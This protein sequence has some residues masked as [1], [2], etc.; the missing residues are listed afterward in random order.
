SNITMK[1]MEY[2]ITEQ[3]VYQNYSDAFSS[4]S[5]FIAIALDPLHINENT[6]ISE[7]GDIRSSFTQYHQK[8]T[9]LSEQL[10]RYETGL[11]DGLDS[12]IKLEIRITSSL[13]TVLPLDGTLS[14]LR[15]KVLRDGIDVTP[16]FDDSCFH[17]KRLSEEMEGDVQWNTVNTMPTKTISV[18]VTDLVNRSAI[19]ICEFEYFYS[20]TMKI[21]KSGFITLNEE[22]PGPPGEDAYQ[23][24]V[25]CSQGTVFRQ[26]QDFNAQLVARV[27]QGTQEITDS[28]GDTDF[29]WSRSS[30]DTQGDEVWNSSHYSTGG[31][32]LHITHNDVAGKSV[33]NCDLLHERSA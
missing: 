15:V 4:L 9:L 12:R 8:L 33:F 16:E 24:Q 26:G 30:E 1:A 2:G 21:A 7:L 5:F 14:T 32:T 29:R 17:W 11:L 23:V 27:W 22:T 19:F 20:A 10:F 28:F 31:K 25:L 6:N 18:S 3:E 13:G